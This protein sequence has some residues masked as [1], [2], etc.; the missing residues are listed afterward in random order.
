M[1]T[2]IDTVK[3]GRAAYPEHNTSYLEKVG[4]ITVDS[5]SLIPHK[6][7]NGSEEDIY[8]NRQEDCKFSY[9]KNDKNKDMNA[10]E[11]IGAS[12]TIEQNEKLNKA[13][14]KQ[15]KQKHQKSS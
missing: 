12:K 5:D 11:T 1:K 14:A 2:Y 6:K 13:R 15:L 9:E 3:K 8:N 7:K 10:K 4:N